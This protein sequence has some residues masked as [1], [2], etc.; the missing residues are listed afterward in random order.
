MYGK[1]LQGNDLPQAKLTPEIVR[2]LRYRHAW[3]KERIT[4]LNEKYGIRAMADDL[5]VSVG[6]IVKVLNYQSWRHVL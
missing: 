4:E 6:A 3:K 2:E 1:C 5:G